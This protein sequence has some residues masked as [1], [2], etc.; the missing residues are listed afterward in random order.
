MVKNLHFACP[1]CDYRRVVDHVVGAASDRKTL[2]WRT[3]DGTGWPRHSDE[4]KRMAASNLRCTQNNKDFSAKLFELKHLQAK[5]GG[6]LRPEAVVVNAKGDEYATLD[7][8]N[9]FGQNARV[10]SR[11]AVVKIVVATVI[12]TIIVSTSWFVSMLPVTLV[13]LLVPTPVLCFRSMLS[14]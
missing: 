5:T 6:Q 11:C 8:G 7:G 4:S 9:H 12:L 13:L 2:K 10:E 3:S 1:H 14:S